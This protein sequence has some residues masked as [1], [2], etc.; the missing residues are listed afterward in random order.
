MNIAKL[1]IKNILRRRSRFLFTLL[2]ITIGM[3]SFVVL[4]AMSDNLRAE[5]TQQANTMGADI[6]VTSRTNCPFVLMSLL[7]G[8][9]V[10]E[11]IPMDV[12]YQIANIEGVVNAVPHLTLGASINE[13]V[14]SLV[15]ILPEKM[16]SHRE[17]TINAGE[18]FQDNE[19]SVV[20]GYNIAYAFE[21]EVGDVLVFRGIEFPVTAILNE[22]SSSD[23][24]TV[25]MPL[26]VAQ[27]TY[28]LGDYV[29]YIAVSVDNVTR[30]EQSKAAIL[31]IAN[32]TVLTDD[33]L[34]GSVLGIVGS[35]NITLQIIAAVAII[36]AVFGIINTMM[37]AIYERRRE[38]GI[39]RAMGSKRSVIFKIFIFESG[40]YGLLGGLSGLGVGFVVSYF[41]APIIRQNQFIGVMGNP[42]IAITIAP[43]PIFFVMGLSILIAVVSGL[44]PAWKASKLTPMEAIRN[45]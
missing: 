1:V 36:A 21:L 17:W 42:D 30:V 8:D 28:D 33:E 40:L 34:L 38:I 32:V 9:D 13:S 7:T 15:G 10:P 6:V 4:L 24:S 11:S 31:N 2:G 43:A 29:S 12:F 18:Y 5:V 44:Y 35:V 14:V 23:D 39:M 41:T 20:I 45:V 22:H 27:E 3:A 37:T 26:S 16:K 25:F 19:K